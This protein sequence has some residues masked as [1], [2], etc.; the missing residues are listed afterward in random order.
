MKILVLGASGATGKLLVSQLLNRNISVRIV[1]RETAMISV[2]AAYNKNIE[3]V[4]GNTNEKWTAKFKRHYD[5]V[6]VAMSK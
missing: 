6:K 3:I 2:K 1:L 4:R 5:E